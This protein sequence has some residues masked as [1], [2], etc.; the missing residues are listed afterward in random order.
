MIPAMPH[1]AATIPAGFRPIDMGGPFIAANGPLYGHWT[2]EKLQLGFRVEPR[3]TNPVGTCHGGMLASFCDMLLP[4]M[5]MYQGTDGR[6]SFLPTINLQ[7]DYIGA[8]PLGA[9]VQGEG[10]VLQ[11]TRTMVF[12]QALVT[13]DGAPALRCSGIFRYRPP[14]D[15]NAPR[16]FDPLRLRGG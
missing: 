4:A 16:D 6:R 9:W 13:A 12:A 5:T 14:Q 2:G 15:E 11:R 8:A 3:H 1:D 7:V 10:D